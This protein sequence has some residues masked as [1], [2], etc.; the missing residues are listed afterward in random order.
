VWNLR[1]R[2]LATQPLA[3]AIRS[4]VEN[5]TAGRQCEVLT[6]GEAHRVPE[7]IGHELLR[8]AQEAAANAVKHGNAQRIAITLDFTAAPRMRLAI[9]DN[10]TG[11]DPATPV[12]AGHFGL[13]GMRERV[14]KLGG[15]FHL[16]SERGKGTAVEVVV[17]LEKN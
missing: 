7:V 3:E 10:G 8:V 1:D 16:R 5:V 6:H 4:A 2:S 11:F 9:E 15:E 12:P 14:E 17:P 13:I